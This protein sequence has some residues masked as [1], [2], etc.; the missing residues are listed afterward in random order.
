MKI[1]LCMA[2]LVAFAVTPA[3]AGEGHVS[4]RSL[5]NMGLA[6]MKTLSDSQGMQVR[7]LS[8][9]IAG[10]GSFASINGVGGS[11]GTI[12]FYLAAGH[13]SSQCLRQ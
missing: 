13:R 10:G 5:S 9:A 12:N 2:S 3:F 8:I 4:N 6:G 11:A 1:V 7:G